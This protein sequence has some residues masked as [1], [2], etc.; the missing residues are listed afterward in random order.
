MRGRG[1]SRLALPVIDVV[2]WA[3]G[4]SMGVATRY[5]WILTGCRWRTADGHGPRRLSQ[6]GADK[7]VRHVLDDACRTGS[8]GT[9][10][11]GSAV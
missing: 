7:R 2:S 6:D 8:D 10:D 3:V 11:D 9:P 4:L 1:P 5:D